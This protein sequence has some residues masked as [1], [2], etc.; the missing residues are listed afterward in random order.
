MLLVGR[1]GNIE[2]SGAT[3]SFYLRPAGFAMNTLQSGLSTS[4]SLSP[5]LFLF[6]LF[7]VFMTLR[8]SRYVQ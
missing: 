8:L 1:P 6:F 3:A 4:P 2:E 7:S 5:L